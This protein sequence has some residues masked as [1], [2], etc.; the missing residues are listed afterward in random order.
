MMRRMIISG[1]PRTV[2]DGETVALM[3]V[4]MQARECGV[5]G[6]VGFLW[7]CGVC[8]CDSKGMA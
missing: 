4:R 8:I 1:E 2:Q 3:E 7:G 6:V 5:V